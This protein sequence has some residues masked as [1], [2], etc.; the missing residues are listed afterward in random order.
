MTH[1][2]YDQAEIPKL[3]QAKLMDADQAI[4]SLA[5]DVNFVTFGCY[6]A[7]PVALAKA[8]AQ[9]AREGYFKQV[10]DTYLFRCSSQVTEFFNDPEVLESIH[11]MLPFIGGEIGSLLKTARNHLDKV[12]YPEYISGHFS[13]M[14]SGFLTQY[15]DPDLH[16]FQVSP[17]DENGYFSFG[18]DG[19]F[20]IP[21]ARRAKRIV[22]EVNENMPR[23]FG[24]GIIHL[25]EID[26]IVEHN[27]ELLRLPTKAMTDNDH[28]IA[29]FIIDSIPDGACIQL[30][31]GGVPDAVGKYLLD[32]N[33]LGIHTE[34]MCAS[35]IDLV[36]NGNV[37]N[38]YKNIHRHHTVFNVAML[39]DSSYYKVMD[40]NP[41]MLCYPAS[42]VNDASV[43]EK[44]DKMISINS[45]VE[46]DLLGQVASESVAW[47]QITGTGGQVDFV[48][49]ASASKGGKSFLA[50][51]ST[52]K[53]GTISKIVPR[54]NN[55]VT[56][57]RT[58]VQHVVTE[59][60]CVN[61]AG[62]SN[63]KRAKALINLAHPDFR[64]SL[65]E[66][67]KAMGLIR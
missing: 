30:G 2:R 48:R 50:A 6:A 63:V 45:F 20:S 62:M 59:Y 26:A 43:I 13:H 3:Y 35:L 25:S 4:R 44:I 52:A 21:A 23:T 41:S 47:K 28:R 7:T 34:L 11:L 18:L 40:N 58:D 16:M 67:A 49:G 31:I 64:P 22:V 57:A 10:I 33:D 1:Y 65:T 15:G 55:I 46:I 37:T 24:D 42:Y 66:Q 12:Q 29:D 54:L 36:K 51:A 14:E 61:L 8:Y 19:S 38:K 60:G 5:Q 32:K 27:S 9:A 56:T 39:P 53:N 17:M